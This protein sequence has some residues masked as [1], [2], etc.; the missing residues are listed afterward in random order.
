VIGTNN[1]SSREGRMMSAYV[2]TATAQG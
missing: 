2:E 1:G